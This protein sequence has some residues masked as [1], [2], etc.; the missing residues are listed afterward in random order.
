MS[1]LTKML[2]YA[3][4][5]NTEQ[6]RLAN[7]ESFKRIVLDTIPKEQKE[8]LLTEGMNATTLLQEEV[9]KTII[10][11]SQPIQVVRNIFPIIKT[12]TN[13]IRVTLEDGALGKAVDVAE[14]A[15]IPI[16]VEK[17][18][19]QNITIKKIGCRPVITNE[20]IEDGLWDMVAFE[21]KRAGQKLE[22]KLNYDVINEAVDK[23]T[24]SDIAETTNTTC[25][26]QKLIEGVQ[27]I[28]EKDYMPTDIILTP[29][30][31]GHL[32]SSNN[33]LQANYAGDAKAL[34]NYDVG[35]L[36]GLRMHRLTVDGGDQDYKWNN[37]YDGSGE[38]GALICDP[39]YCKI[40]M[41][42]DITV[43]KYDDPIHDL[44]GIAATMRYGVKTLEPKKAWVLKHS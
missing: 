7:K 12:N 15:A 3:Y 25:T 39:S 32:I 21:L 11:G 42:R 18:T 29:T 4:A 44:V 16:D 33:L 38:L 1:K 20:L 40:A 27:A 17:F 19:T 34:R 35:K 31:E 28:Q 6:K 22:H 8:L 26:V 43:E 13:Q 10:E 36:L 24:Y 37:G 14:G 5:G 9:Y 23:T 30:A 2:E 41:R